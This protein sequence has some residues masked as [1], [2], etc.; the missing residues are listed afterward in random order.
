MDK[1]QPGPR[2]MFAGIAIVFAW[3]LFIAL[4]LFF[5]A[6]GFSIVLRSSFL[7]LTYH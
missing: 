2:I 1:K 5:Y 4:W 7:R 6:S 3:L